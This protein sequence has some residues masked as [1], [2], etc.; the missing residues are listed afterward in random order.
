M[1]V[2]RLNNSVLSVMQF[3]F[4]PVYGHFPDNIV[5]DRRDINRQHFSSLHSLSTNSLSVLHD[6]LLLIVEG[7]RENEGEC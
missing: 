3:S 1:C 7:M 6:Q 4:L 5:Y 2:F